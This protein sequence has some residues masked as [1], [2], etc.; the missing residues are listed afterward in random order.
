MI[1]LLV[2]D[3]QRLMW[4]CSLHSCSF[5]WTTPS[6]LFWSQ[7][8]FLHMKFIIRKDYFGSYFTFKYSRTW[9][10]GHI[11]CQMD[12]FD[13]RIIQPASRNCRTASI[14]LDIKIVS[15]SDPK[16]IIP[17]GNQPFQNTKT[18]VTNSNQKLAHNIVMTYGVFSIFIRI[19]NFLLSF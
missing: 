14:F 16:S 9:S 1:S 7:V 12:D 15:H 18:S 13:P 11:F 17:F 6:R 4:E 19:V 10:Y 5:T 8:K 3:F 2:S